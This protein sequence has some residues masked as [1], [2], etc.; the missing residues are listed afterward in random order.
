M[1]KI[2]ILLE[3]YEATAKAAPFGS[4]NLAPTKNEFGMGRE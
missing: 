2:W 3:S 4:R 1:T